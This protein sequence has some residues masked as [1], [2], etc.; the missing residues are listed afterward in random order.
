MSCV[1]VEWLLAG[2]E[3]PSASQHKRMTYTNCCIY[4]VVLPDYNPTQLISREH[5]LIPGNL[6]A[7]SRGTVILK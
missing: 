3:L 5:V 1:Y 2:L 4:S 7:L 6:S